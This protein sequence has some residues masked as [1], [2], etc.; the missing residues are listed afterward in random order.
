MKNKILANCKEMKYKELKVFV[1]FIDNTKSG[2]LEFKAYDLENT[3]NESR[4]QVEDSDLIAEGSVRFDG[5]INFQINNDYLHSCGF[6]NSFIEKMNQINNLIKD[7]HET[8]T[9]FCE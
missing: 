1:E 7:K 4:E 3:R 6:L 9:Y 2:L 5:C 8:L